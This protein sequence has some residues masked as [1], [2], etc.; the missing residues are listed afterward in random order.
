MP[1]IDFWNEIK[2][3][4]TGDEYMTAV[5]K[6][7]QSPP[8][9]PFTQRNGLTFLKGRMEPY[10]AHDTKMG[11]HYGVLRTFKKLATQF[12]LPSMHKIV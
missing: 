8:E 2:Q 11:G 3:A 4:A 12:Y 7:V 9:G 6:L 5:N 1:Q 10:E